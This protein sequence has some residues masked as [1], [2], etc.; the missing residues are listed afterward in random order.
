MT[1]GHTVSGKVGL[2]PRQPDAGPL[3]APPHTEERRP[4]GEHV[5]TQREPGRLS[6]TSPHSLKARFS[7]SDN[8]CPPE[9][10]SSK[11]SQSLCKASRTKLYSTAT[12]S[13]A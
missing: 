5:P 13:R 11:G 8:F 10:S 7:S 2:K 1:Q 12:L 3:L 9:A 4:C 6:L